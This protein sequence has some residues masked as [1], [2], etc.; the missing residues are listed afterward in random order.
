MTRWV[1]RLLRVSLKPVFEE[2]S[3][4]RWE[5]DGVDNI[6]DGADRDEF[7]HLALSWVQGGETEDNMGLHEG[8]TLR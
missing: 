7:G 1:Q 6:M 8:E 5:A 3:R 4:L 2:K